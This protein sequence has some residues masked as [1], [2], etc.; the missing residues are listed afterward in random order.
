MKDGKPQFPKRTDTL[1]DWR[2]A[3]VKRVCGGCGKRYAIELTA[4]PH[5]GMH[6]QKGEGE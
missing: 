6:K 4:C 5:C 2:N 3:I 1:M